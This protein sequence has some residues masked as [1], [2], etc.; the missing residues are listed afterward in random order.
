MPYFPSSTDANEPDFEKLAVRPEITEQDRDFAAAYTA[1]LQRTPGA[2]IAAVTVGSAVDL[3]DT[4]ASSIIPGIERQEVNNRFLGA[5]GSPGLT[6]WFD[7]NRGAVEVGSGVLGIVASD[8]IAG[9]IL[10]PGS[11]VMRG[12]RQ[13]PYVKKIA[14]LDRQYEQAVRLA[15]LTSKEA[16]QRGLMGME[17]FAVGEMNLASLGT[18]ALTT[19]GNFAKRSL[20]RAGLA[21]GLARNVTTEGV[22]AATLHTN[23]FLYSDELAHNIAWGVAGLG[24]G[25]GIDRMIDIYTL[26]KIANSAQ[27]R[28]L[29]AGAY[30]VTGVEGQ[31]I[32]SFDTAT[33]LLRAAG[34]LTEKLGSMFPSQGAITDKI[35]S[36]AISAS[37]LGVRRGMTERAQSLFS[38]RE[39][40]ATP[41]YD[42]A[43]V[44]LNKVTTKGISGVSRAGFGT[45][46]EGLGAPLKE[47][48]RR[49]PTFL[50]G[51][52][53][54]GTSVDNMTLEQV[55]A[56]RGKNLDERLR[57]AEK[58]LTD[59]GQ[60]KRTR[61]RTKEGER[62]SDELIP[63][64]EEEIALLQQEVRELKFK[65]DMVPM[66][67]LEPG[68]WAPLELA[69]VAENFKPKAIVED[70]GLG[71][72][73]VKLWQ[74][75]KADPSDATIAIR[76][77][78][79]MFL[80]GNGKLESLKI[81]DMLSLYQIG[82]KMVQ[83]FKNTGATFT[84]PNKPNWFQLDLAEQIIKATD[85]PAAVVF[86]PKMTRQSAQVESF[87]QK[88]SALRRR[89]VTAKRAAG[90]HLDATLDD[91]Q[92]F[93]QKIFFNLPRLTSYQAGLIGTMESPLDLLLAG[94]K[95]GDDV[96]KLSHQELLKLLNDAKKI[97]G[98][99]EETEDTL[100]ALH[101][102]SFNFL[103]GTDGEIKPI[104][105]YR[106]PL[107][108][109]EWTRD[110]LFMRQ[111]VKH[112]HV[113]DTLVGETADPITRE[114]VSSLLSD[115]NTSE[116]RRIMELADDQQRSFIP[117]FSES[118]P[119]TTAG[120]L[121]N[122]VT[123]RERRDV[124]SLIMR[125][126]STV[127]ENQR[128]ITGAIMKE[129]IQKVMGDTITLVN[130]A[131]NA[132]TKLLLNQFHSFR[133]GWEIARDAVET[134]LPDGTK[135]FK[136]VLDHQSATN[137]LR[138]SRMFNRDLKK[139]DFL[140]NPNGT[141]VVLDELG[142]DVQNRL[143][144][145][146]QAEVEMKNTLLR[147]Q[148]LPEI[149]VVPFYVPPA[150][151]KGKYVGYTFD[152]EDKVVPD[153]TIIADSPEELSRLKAELERSDQWKA[154]YSFRQRT[155]IES[156]MTLWDR[157]QMD[158]IA[159]NTTAIQPKKHN[160]GR[161]SGSLLNLNAFD[162]ALVTLRDNMMKHGSD[163]VEVLFDDPIKAAYARSKI[164][165]VES[166]VGD[167][168]AAKHSSI[169]DRYV[170]NLLGRN[171]LNAKD[172]FFGGAY[173]WAEKRLN[174]LLSSGPA[175]AA[176][177]AA[178]AFKDFIRVANPKKPINGD[179]FNRL[180]KELGPYMPFKNAAQL[181]ARESG[182]RVP[183]DVEA[184][185]AKLSWFESASRLRWFESMHAAVNIGSILA[186]TPSVIKALQPMAG[187]T[188][189]EAARRNSNLVMMLATPDGKGM[190][191][192]N[193][194]KLL[195]AGMKAAW[196]KTPDD[197]TK[198]AIRLGYMDQEVSEFQRQWGA[199]DSKEGWRGFMFGDEAAEGKGF[200]AKLK[201]SGGLDKWMGVLS[202]KSEA[203]TRQWGMYMGREVAI[204]LGIH[205]VD[206]QISF[207]HD[208]TNKLIANYDPANRPEIFQGPLGAPIGLF[209][210][211]VLNF[212]Q[213]MF[214]YVETQNTRALAIQYATQAGLFGTSSVPGWDA[215]NWAFFDRGEG[216]N[217]DPVESLYKRFGT[218]DGDL[219]MHGVL[220][221]LPKIFGG[222][223]ISLYTRGDVQYRMP[224]NPISAVTDFLGVTEGDNAANMPVADT[225]RRVA[226]GVVQGVAAIRDAGGLSWTQ[227]AEILS[228]MITNRPLAGMIESFGAKGYDTSWDGQVVAQSRSLAEKVWRSLGVRTMRQQKEI[229]QFYS[230]KNAREE[231][232]ARQTSLR[233]AT[234]AAI[235]AGDYDEVPKIFAQYV[236]AGGDP[237]YYTRWVKS[238]FSAALDSRGERQLQNALKKTDGSQNAYIARLLDSQIDVNE[239]DT[240]DD[241]Y[242]RQ[243]EIDALIAQGWQTNPETLSVE[244]EAELDD[245]LL[246]DSVSG[247]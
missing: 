42:Q 26:R 30:D 21:R 4:V 63:L 70:G 92:L 90:D 135:A 102:N 134:T 158:W 217:D 168:G 61:Y 25:A 178:Q 50:Y 143:Q 188:V 203:F 108:P 121:I 149:K 38:R 195:W 246:N 58:L 8:M 145:L 204:S 130:N 172:S 196:K 234:R 68:E 216:T 157:A 27:V 15:Q 105:S 87:A 40:L 166:A 110:E 128:R 19:S 153:M 218:T 51:V 59:G 232:L 183:A 175:L 107:S 238:A 242:G 146:H 150:S 72:D 99:T 113:Q 18:T 9:R 77:D 241:D 136:F 161:S 117:G 91:V 3:M 109:M 112:A 89:E 35:T 22:M 6:K 116:A 12:L 82:H 213:R 225:A 155:E 28:R 239:D 141:E 237:R 73:N 17:R 81:D 86:P 132:K 75:E 165:Q 198:K 131:R 106:R 78:G 179:K 210:S 32:H 95:R 152:I 224:V 10:K 185:S 190:G 219:I 46:N 125:A 191:V 53:E 129:M 127:N 33:K 55:H 44:E 122:A 97:Q 199:I 209:Q 180:A 138:Y 93:E 221:N 111:S 147:S 80:P 1:G 240:A 2:A 140:L 119:Q 200:G 173:D 231:Q 14:T 235:R 194:P 41:T 56:L 148:G 229:G 171:A 45:K 114:I 192:V 23:D 103:R 64:K 52:E 37:E 244:D 7:E 160:F 36:L 69:K 62:F 197:F 79:E 94:L 226:R 54:I 133:Q 205:D 11:V 83:D 57:V 67:L 163:I 5:I 39:A 222:D 167:K 187:E 176:S 212:Y 162:E 227:T 211:Y 164:A 177:D 201:R 151:M 193:V 214:R 182:G 24:L 181:A 66:V 144:T 170:Q 100:A 76:S 186:N 104:I 223:G 215:L 230:N 101:G 247:W 85:N 154:G 126:A 207:A 34:G 189:E 139:G 245:S 202:D 47:S 233:L 169:Y 88:V 65:K 49:D 98:F 156:F 123:T 236:E 60:W 71:A 206:Q 208:L 31:R 120:S 13:L 48:L 16:A 220:S 96:R 174:G 159:P 137:Q 115:P 243:A 118:A 43:F 84:L 20:V 228:N 74:R 184:I 142:M 29:N 124:D